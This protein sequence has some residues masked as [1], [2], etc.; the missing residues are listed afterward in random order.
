MTDAR[1]LTQMLGGRWHRRYGAAPCP[2]CQPERR[3]GQNALTLADGNEGLVL[4]CKKSACSFRDLL[5]AA[6]IAPGDYSAPDPA[7]IAQRQAADRAE[8]E[9]R[10]RQA[11]QVWRE[12]QQIEGS[13]AEAYLR[14]RRITGPLPPSL[15][16]HPTAWHAPTAQH[17]PAMVALVDGSD[18]P[19]IHRTYLRADGSGKAVV[20]PAK[21]MLGAVAGGAVRLAGAQGPLVIAEGIETA[22]SLSCGLL[23][24]PATIWAALSA[25]GIRGLRLPDVPGRLTIASDGDT[26]GREAAHVLAERAHGLGWTV[27]LLPAPEGRDWNDI[28][29]MKGGAA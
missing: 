9:K 8:A 17:L 18:L 29:C 5:A 28:L 7:I 27:S 10:A 3:K 23:R 15:R 14:G 22:L 13:P 19:A 11:M 24:S 20:D 6:G 4:H 25:S 26:A 2:I 1:T 12:A 16:F 21:A